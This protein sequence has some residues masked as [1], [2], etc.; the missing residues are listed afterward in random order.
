MLKS[1]IEKA[2]QKKFLIPIS[3]VVI[4]SFIAIPVGAIIS[5]WVGWAIGW[6]IMLTAFIVFI[7]SLFLYSIFREGIKKVVD[8]YKEEIS[9]SS[10]KDNLKELIKNQIEQKLGNS[11][12]DQTT[13]HEKKMEGA[14][15]KRLNQYGK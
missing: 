9:E 14:I 1:D 5:I 11:T 2:G 6:K 7:V 13:Y 12:K 15:K 3:Y 4:L 8:K 10:S